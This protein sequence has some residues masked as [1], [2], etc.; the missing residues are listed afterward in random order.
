MELAAL[1]AERGHHVQLWEQ[2]GELGGQLRIA[3]RARE[4]AAYLDFVAF[5]QRRLAE[6]GV[7]VRL[8]ATATPAAVVAEGPD[9]L[10]VAT[11]A[12]ARRPDVPG[13]D[14]PHV[15]D[16]WSALAATVPVGRRVVVVA[17]EDHLQPL[18]IAAHLADAGHEV[19]VLYATPAVAPLV[20]RYSI[21]APLARLGAAGARIVVMER[22]VRIEPGCVVTRHVYSRDERVH[23][24]VDTV[25]LACGGQ[26]VTGL[27]TAAAG[28]LP[29]VHILGDAYAPRRI[30]FATRQ[31]YELA[32]RI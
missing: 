15:V 30:S 28:A 6:A 4:N 26:P 5:Q 19:R 14:A 25:V 23:A 27:Y 21:G 20:G 16:G 7:D 32:R 11:G 24:E 10:A 29:E 17:M 12:V 31:A 9:V 22:V 3:A 18:T 1:L 13:V 8:G 2:R